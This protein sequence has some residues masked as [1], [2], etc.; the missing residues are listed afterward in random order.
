VEAARG[1]LLPLDH[2]SL[3]FR[4]G[5]GTALGANR[6]DPFARF[7]FGGFGNNWVDHREIK[8]FR[9]AESFPG[10][11]INQA[12][13]ATYGKAQL[14]WTS[15]P[16][17]FRRVGVPSAYLRWAALS[18]FATGLVTDPDN[19]TDRSTLGSLGAQ[20]DFRLVTLSHLDSTL[21]FGSAVAGGDGVP[22][23]SVMM[24]SLKI[25]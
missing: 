23:R 24:V 2:S 17:R 22:A 14:E 11:E 9:S 8:Q 19:A 12:G 5:A 10:L 4:A 18:V 25:M 20:L 21:S 3:W 1:F 15:P 13:G 7:Y 6:S 16:L